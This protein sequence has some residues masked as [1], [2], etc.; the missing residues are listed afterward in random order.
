MHGSCNLNGIVALTDRRL[1]VANF[2]DG[3]LYRV[4]LD[5]AGGRTIVPITGVTVP[6]AAGMALDEDR[7]V[8]AD[9]AGLSVVAVGDDVASAMLVEQIRDPSFRD[10]AAVAVADDRYLVVNL[11]QSSSHKTPGQPTLS[12]ASPRGTDLRDLAGPN[13]RLL[14][15]G[16]RGRRRR[17]GKPVPSQTW[18]SSGRA[19]SGAA[20]R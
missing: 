14:T 13:V 12:P 3:L 16:R 1:I 18:P 5:E 2:A 20:I 6:L 11:D 10:T 17:C 9:D 4:D 7:L 8:V 15:A 19:R